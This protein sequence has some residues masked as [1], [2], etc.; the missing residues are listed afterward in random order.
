M[1]KSHQRFIRQVVTAIR[2]FVQAIEV[3]KKFGHICEDEQDALV[4]LQIKMCETEE[5]RSL[6][7]LLVRHYNPKYHSKQY[8]QVIYY[9]LMS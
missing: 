5:L 4:Q 2:E 7:V 9:I 6:L 8:L 3:Y 1:T